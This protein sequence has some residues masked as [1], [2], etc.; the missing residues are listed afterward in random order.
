[1]VGHAARVPG[2]SKEGA[3][4]GALRRRQRAP[5]RASRCGYG[6]ESV[7]SALT[8]AA[9]QRRSRSQPTAV[10]AHPALAEIPALPVAR[11][12]SIKMGSPA[13]ST[14]HPAS[15]EIPVPLVT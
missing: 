15:K 14:P 7:H 6:P 4:S 2:A 13:R 12:R 11:S 1:M 3:R 5:R 9:T 8:L 10:G